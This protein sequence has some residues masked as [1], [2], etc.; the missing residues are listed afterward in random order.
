MHRIWEP[1]VDTVSL[2]QQNGFKVMEA[3]F[4]K[5]YEGV[6]GF[7]DVPK[8]LIYVNAKDTSDQQNYTVAHEL[9]HYLLNH[10]EQANFEDEY[11]VLLRE[12]FS[13]EFTTI[14]KEA[15]LFA[16]NLLVPAR[17]L[18]KWLADY[19]YATN[20]ELARI[21]GVPANVIRYRRHLVY[22]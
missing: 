12:P 17:F 11:S 1:P 6:A 20:E 10:H 5:D 4:E 21:F 2:A 9:G 8:K 3:T 13:E 19:P 14:E 16:D 15:N 18:S 7:I 22:A